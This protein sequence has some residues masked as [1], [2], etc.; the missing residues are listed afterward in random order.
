[1]E[2]QGRHH[3]YVAM[4]KPLRIIVADDEPD[5]RHLVAAALAGCGYDVLQARNG[6]ELLDEI[7]GS[8]VSGD[9]TG[10]PDVI[11]ADV[12]M[13]GLTGLEILDVVRK[14]HWETGVI[15]MTA[16]ADR[17]TREE[18]R[19]LGADALFAK[20]FDPENLVTA[21]ANMTPPPEGCRGD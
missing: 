4:D 15:L 21:V 16:Y 8:L 3:R 1:M 20:P 5:I 12:R 11:I 14:A 10:R 17:T 13:P 2:E 18:A 9:P 6:A 19:R 7:G